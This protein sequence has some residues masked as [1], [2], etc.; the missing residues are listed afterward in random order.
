MTLDHTPASTITARLWHRILAHH[1]NG[2]AERMIRT[3]TERARAMILDSQAPLKFWGEAVNTAVYLHQRMP[4][5]GLTRR[6]DRDGHKAPY[7]TPYEMLPSYGKP[8]YD[9]PLD[10]PT[11]KRINYKRTNQKLGARSR[12]YMM[13]GYV[14]DS[15]TLRRIC[16]PEHNTVKAQ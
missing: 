15:T 6:D 1:N 3:I 16:N 10:N 4:N 14:H 9:K 11:C 7:H 8:S 13:V 5:D 12:A 2:V